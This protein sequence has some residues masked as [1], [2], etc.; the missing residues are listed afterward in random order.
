MADD[1]E[2]DRKLYETVLRLTA[3]S[4]HRIASGC[5]RIW[6]D[7]SHSMEVV[8]CK[9]GCPLEGMD[10]NIHPTRGAQHPN[11]DGAWIYSARAF[12]KL[13]RERCDGK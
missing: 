11:I 1:D 7:G 10:I 2:E 13:M 8:G 9:K 6:S 12:Q 3:L 4:P 5:E